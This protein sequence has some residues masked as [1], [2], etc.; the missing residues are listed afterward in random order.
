MYVANENERLKAEEQLGEMCRKLLAN[1]VIQHF[2]LEL[3]K[4][5]G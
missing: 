2:R 5:S 1:P 4:V 3:E